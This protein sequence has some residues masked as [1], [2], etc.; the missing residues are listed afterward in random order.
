M[1]KEISSKTAAIVFAVA[2]V[3]LLGIAYKLFFTQAALVSPNIKKGE[4]YKLRPTAGEAYH[5]PQGLGLPPSGS[6]GR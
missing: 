6:A 4:E 5:N 3:I 2:A 1:K